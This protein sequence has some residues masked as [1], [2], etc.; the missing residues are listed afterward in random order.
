MLSEK[1]LEIMRKNGRVH[2]K[3]FDAVKK[4]LVAGVSAKQLDD[5]ALEMCKEA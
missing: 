3:V 1:E 2:K 4:M 5:M